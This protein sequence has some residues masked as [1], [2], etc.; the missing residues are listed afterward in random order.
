MHMITMSC[1]VVDIPECERGLDDCDPNAN[2][3]NT[4][5]SYDCNCKTGF[6]GDGFACTGWSSKH[7]TNKYQHLL[8]QFL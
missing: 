4:F 2:C 8:Q 7:G 5:G 3:I 1:L 6:I